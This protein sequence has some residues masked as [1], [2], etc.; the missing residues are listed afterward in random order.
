MLLLE[1]LHHHAR[2]A[3]VAE[4]HLARVVEVR[5]G[6]VALP[7]LLDRQVEDLGRE[8]LSAV[9]S[10]GVSLELEAGGK[11]CLGDLELLGGRL[12]GREPVLELVAGPGE[13]AREPVLGV[14]HI[15]AKISVAAASAPTAR[16]RRAGPRTGAGARAAS[17]AADR[18]A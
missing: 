6:V 2:M 13:R 8:P 11:R 9:R 14:A 7:H 15:Q 1:D 5:V 12:R 10:T 4:Q 18:R 16:A 17:A 3:P